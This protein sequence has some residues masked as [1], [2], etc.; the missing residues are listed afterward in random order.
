MTKRLSKYKFSLLKFTIQIHISD[1]LLLYMY[2][3]FYTLMISIF[4]MLKSLLQNPSK[5][6]FSINVRRMTFFLLQSKNEDVDFT[7]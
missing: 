7:R 1:P 4:T 2:Q 3:Y 5:T 6:L